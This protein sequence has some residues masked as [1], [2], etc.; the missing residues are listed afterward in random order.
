MTPSV[1]ASHAFLNGP[2]PTSF[3]SRVY[4]GGLLRLGRSLNKF[5]IDSK[6]KLFPADESYSVYG[7][8]SN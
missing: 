5:S 2:S 3:F 7:T 4:T 6:V 1:D 8:V